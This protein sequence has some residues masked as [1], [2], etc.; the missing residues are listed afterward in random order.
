VTR[1]VLIEDIPQQLVGEISFPPSVAWQFA[2]IIKFVGE[3]VSNDLSWNSPD[4]GPVTSLT[5]DRPTLG[6]S[7]DL[8]AVSGSATW[9]KSNLQLSDAGPVRATIVDAQGSDEDQFQLIVQAK[10]TIAFANANVSTDEGT[11]VTNQINWGDQDASS[12][13]QIVS[14]EMAPGSSGVI[15]QISDTSQTTGTA[16][17]INNNPLQSDSGPQTA[18][19]TDADGNTEEDTFNLTVNQG[20]LDAP[21]I[22]ADQAIVDIELPIGSA[23]FFTAKVSDADTHPSNP[24]TAFRVFDGV[25]DVTS[26]FTI[27]VPDMG[28]GA[29]QTVS[30]SSQTLTLTDDQRVLSLEVEDGNGL[31]D[32]TQVTLNITNID[33]LKGLVDHPIDKP[34]AFVFGPALINKGG[35]DVREEFRLRFAGWSDETFTRPDQGQGEWSAIYKLS[36]LNGKTLTIDN[37]TETSGPTSNFCNFDIENDPLAFEVVPQ[38]ALAA[39]TIGVA[40]G[41]TATMVLT[42]NALTFLYFEYSGSS[43][44]WT[45][46]LAFFENPLDGGSYRNTIQKTTNGCLPTPP[47]G[48]QQI[49]HNLTD[50]IGLGS[51]LFE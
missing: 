50:Q 14:I 12:T 25:T 44:S 34:T 26:D 16:R 36:Q 35:C 11:A 39:S 15:D 43:S 5:T 33:P 9:S 20:S 13:K 40:I 1:E 48:V 27:N 38:S 23:T 51:V 37:S 46:S 2:Q 47:D 18:I 29:E 19:I 6:P 32:Q 49:M 31:K 8:T 30:Y 22:A 28:D 4:S 41:Q 24:Y 17:W 10:P 3:S 21:I 45:Y 7:S 42:Q